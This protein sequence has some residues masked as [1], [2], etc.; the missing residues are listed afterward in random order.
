MVVDYEWIEGGSCSVCGKPFEG[1]HLASK[2]TCSNKCR[3]KLHRGL[4]KGEKLALLM[5]ENKSICDQIDVALK[6]IRLNRNVK[7]A[8][9]AI[10]DL[11]QRNRQIIREMADL[12][13][14]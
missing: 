11:R 13:A 3:V 5:D 2:K 6:D 7:Y 9:F 12:L 10:D 1:L 14:N 8:W 4:G